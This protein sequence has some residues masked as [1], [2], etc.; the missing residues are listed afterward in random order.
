[1]A[2]D[3]YTSSVRAVAPTELQMTNI[4][5]GIQSSQNLESRLDRL[6]GLIYKDIEKEAE[7]AG[8]RYGIKNRPS[9]EQ[10]AKSVEKGEDPNAL[11]QKEGTVFG[12]AAREAQA[13][14]FKQ[15]LEY[16]FT[17]E[18]QRINQAIEA[19]A[20]VDIET[21]TTDL[22]AKI[23]SQASVLSSVS[24]NQM[25]KFRAG[26]T[27]KANAVYNNA[28]AQQVLRINAANI[29]KTENSI[30]AYANDLEALLVETDGNVIDTH[31]ILLRDKQRIAEFADR[32]PSKKAELLSKFDIQS[33][34]AYKGAIKNY[35]STHVDHVPEG[36]HLLLE[37]E[38]GNLGKMSKLYNL[39]DQE[40]QDA[41]QKEIIA[42]YTNRNTLNQ[43]MQT[44]LEYNNKA[45]IT[46]IYLNKTTNK[47]SGM[48]AIDKLQKL[49]LNLSRTEIESMLTPIS[50]TN[51]TIKNAIYLK[52]KILFGQA[53]IDDIMTAASATAI[54]WSD[55]KALTDDYNAM[56]TYARRGLNKIKTFMGVNDFND[57][58]LIP[59]FK[60][61]AIDTLSARL[62]R[63]ATNAGQAGTAFDDDAYAMS[64][65]NEYQTSQVTEN[66]NSAI[67]EINLQFDAETVNETNVMDLWQG[68]EEATR[69]YLRNQYNFDRTKLNKIITNLKSLQGYY[70][71]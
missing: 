29:N 18:L 36:S 62:L 32:I 51:D 54:T 20:D 10:I 64:L 50:S 66:I 2:Q 19:G 25:A 63:E 49:G 39:L 61:E 11:F 65:I 23:D 38:K 41:L 68:N 59:R 53:S 42:E 67:E 14:L 30:K 47:I 55:A 70:N 4:Q 35:L 9:L 33:Q 37:L 43:A 45:E 46:D 12:D 6:S 60:R 16:E 27:V 1:M 26:M 56:T 17:N 22:Q 15:D 58:S 71:D 34:L 44:E 48:E 24:P 31:A 8:L 7:K 5:Q 69:K 21:L 40:S 52:R 57:M 13:E 3:R 28:L